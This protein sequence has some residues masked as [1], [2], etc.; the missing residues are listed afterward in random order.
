MNAEI[1]YMFVCKYMSIYIY[2]DTENALFERHSIQ[3]LF[4]IFNVPYKRS[5]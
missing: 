4:P 3:F 1:I 5:R 2:I